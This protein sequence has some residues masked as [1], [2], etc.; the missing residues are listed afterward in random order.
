MGVTDG[1]GTTSDVR[2]TVEP[3]SGRL[4][5]R[6]R[7][8][9]FVPAPVSSDRRAD[10][11]DLFMRFQRVGPTAAA[12]TDVPRC[13]VDWSN[14][15]GQVAF[16][17]SFD[18]W[19]GRD[20]GVDGLILL[21]DWID[22]RSDQSL[23][24]L[25]RSVGPL[26]VSSGASFDTLTNTTDLRDGDVHASGFGLV[27]PAEP[28]SISLVNPE[29]M[30]P[31][32]EVTTEAPQFDELTDLDVTLSSVGPVTYPDDDTDRT[33]RRPGDIRC[34]RGH[35]NANSNH[36]CRVCGESLDSTA[37]RPE[38]RASTATA[39]LRLPDGSVIPIDRAIAIGRSPS[40]EWARVD[41]ASV[42]G[43]PRLVTIDAPATVSRTHILLRL[44]GGAITV[45][46]CDAR[47]R[48]AVIA[49][50]APSPIALAPWEPHIVSIGDIIKL[51]G[52]T[53]LVVTDPA[54]LPVPP[55][56][57]LTAPPPERNE[58]T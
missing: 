47:G 43:I 13:V 1:P 25:D 17:S 18:L 15:M 9:L 6:G 51:G 48:T 58:T 12:H 26:V 44:R 50:D 2:V 54:E 10:V 37:G 31:P 11:D 3:G 14:A 24:S 38:D 27:F 21:H 30:R 53:T 49:V 23:G 7:T 42:D 41:G 5:R 55:A 22:D 35:A 39:G 36:T 52:P 45:T 19:F 20:D 46:D 8:L 32:S 34:P 33:F 29:T 4:A 56:F 40:A 16:D 28:P 57:E